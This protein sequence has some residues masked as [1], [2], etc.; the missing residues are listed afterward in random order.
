MGNAIL[1]GPSDRAFKNFRNL[2]TYLIESL[3]SC[4]SCAISNTYTLV[5]KREQNEHKGTKDH[6]PMAAQQDPLG[7][8]NSWSGFLSIHTLTDSKGRF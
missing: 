7:F 1:M 3:Y 6:E 8:P 5:K 4:L 2:H